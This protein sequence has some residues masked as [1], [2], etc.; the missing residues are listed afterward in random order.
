M[1]SPQSKRSVGACAAAAISI[2]VRGWQQGPGR[3]FPGRLKKREELTHHGN[4]T[5]IEMSTAKHCGKSTHI[6]AGNGMPAECPTS[7]HLTAML[8]ELE[9]ATAV[10]RIT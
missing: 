5:P 3:F 1:K 8:A 4:V 9:E 7:I 6:A 10:T 2:P